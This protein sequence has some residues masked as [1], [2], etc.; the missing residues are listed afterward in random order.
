[1][2]KG[3]IEKEGFAAKKLNTCNR[4]KNG[5][6]RK[7]E[8]IDT[9]DRRDKQKGMRRGHFRMRGQEIEFTALAT[10]NTLKKKIKLLLY[11]R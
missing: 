2:K 5:A 6:L 11:R 3:K 10:M 9:S 7:R 1:M 4:L 8:K